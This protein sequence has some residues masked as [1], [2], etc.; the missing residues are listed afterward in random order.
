LQNLDSRSEGKTIPPAPAQPPLLLIGMG[1]RFSRNTM[2]NRRFILIVLPT[3]HPILTNGCSVGHTDWPVFL[4]FCKFFQ[5]FTT[6]AVT[7]SQ[8]YSYFSI[9]QQNT[10]PRWF[11]S[12]EK[13]QQVGPLELL[14][15]TVANFIRKF[16]KKY[17]RHPVC[18]C[19]GNY[20]GSG[21]SLH[22]SASR[23][24]CCATC[25]TRL[26]PIAHKRYKHISIIIFCTS[27]YDRRLR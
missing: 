2:L 15:P 10:R 9:A 7:K 3:T 6:K 24:E 11:F 20:L 19:F 21:Q 1:F 16:L 26:L 5:T 12:G 8:T 27:L 14:A 13:A 22:T 25:K 17:L 23:L 4:N 18:P